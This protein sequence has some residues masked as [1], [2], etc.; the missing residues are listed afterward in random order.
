VCVCVVVAPSEGNISLHKHTERCN[1]NLF[2]HWM[3]V[4]CSDSKLYDIHCSC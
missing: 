1:I 2:S 3:I 4:D